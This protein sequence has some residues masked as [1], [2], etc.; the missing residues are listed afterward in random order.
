MA[1]EMR[2]QEIR[3]KYLKDMGKDLGPVFHRLRDDLTWLHMKWSQFRKLYGSGPDRVDLLNATAG[4][5]F[6]MLQ[7][8]MWDDILLH[9]ARLTDAD[10]MG[11]HANLS[12][13]ALPQLIDDLCLRAEIEELI[14]TLNDQTSVIREHRNK[15]LA[16]TD[17]HYAL[18]EKDW[19]TLQGISRAKT[20]SI[21]E[22]FRRIMNKME[23]H[24]SKSTTADEYVIIPL[25]DAD[26][27]LTRLA[28]V[29]HV[30]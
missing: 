6:W 22:V 1:Q 7:Q 19:E 8:L 21:L 3:A 12:V 11:K 10:Q 18:P 9:I 14:E 29:K 25:D 26:A 23:E 16:H 24:Y 4:F 5:F 28:S 30:S 13:Q 20:E 27:L 15:R 17:R 2:P